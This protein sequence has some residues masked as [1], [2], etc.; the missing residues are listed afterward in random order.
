MQRAISCLA[1]PTR[2]DSGI[3]KNIDLNTTLMESLP[4]FSKDGE[5]L[6]L[7]DLAEHHHLRHNQS[8]SGSP[9]W[10]IGNTDATC[11]L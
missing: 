11:G 6:T 5:T 10:Q 7:E 2:S 1:A 4:G 3:G 8:R 9:S